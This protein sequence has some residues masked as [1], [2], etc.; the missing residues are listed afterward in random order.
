MKNFLAFI[1]L[2]TT[3]ACTST[4]NHQAIRFDAQASRMTGDVLD[5]EKP[6]PTGRISYQFQERDETFD[7]PVGDRNHFTGVVPQIGLSYGTVGQTIDL[8]GVGEFDF[9]MQQAQLD[10][11]VRFYDDLGDGAAQPYLGVGIAPTW[12]EFDDG[13]SSDDVVT[14]GVYAE[15]GVEHSIGSHMRIGYGV[16]Y[17]GGMDGSINGE[18]VDLDN[19]AATVSLG[20]SF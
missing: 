20:W 7:G 19:F 16:R 6:M 11:G 5:D 3:T 10:L 13:A 18:D 8:E 2:I 17:T 1:L 14:L 12:T 15:L 4:S 9:D